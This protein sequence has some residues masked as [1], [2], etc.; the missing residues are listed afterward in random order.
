MP[1]KSMMQMRYKLTP[2]PDTV[3]A[4]P[5]C[6]W[7]SHRAAA[8]AQ[9]LQHSRQSG[10]QKDG[11]VS[12]SST[13]AADKALPVVQRGT[14]HLDDSAGAANLLAS[15]E[16]DPSATCGT[17]LEHSMKC[18]TMVRAAGQLVVSVGA[19]EHELDS[20]HGQ[21]GHSLDNAVPI[22]SAHLAAIRSALVRAPQHKPWRR[23]AAG[24]DVHLGSEQPWPGQSIRP[25]RSEVHSW[26]KV[27]PTTPQ[28]KMVFRQVTVWCTV[29]SG[30]NVILG[31]LRR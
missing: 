13:T 26:M 25:N 30:H 15:A 9:F 18:G 4:Q 29:A 17:E 20:V 16:G 8:V 12:Q 6:V 31:L 14:E 28:T 23:A 1:C 27:A 21:L 7:P 19:R 11:S 24:S 22:G 3:Q 5:Q 10:T 2:A